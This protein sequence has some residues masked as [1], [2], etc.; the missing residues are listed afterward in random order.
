MAKI[1]LY[2][3]VN[4]GVSANL[5]PAI[6][7]AR[8]Q[9][10]ALNRLGGTVASLTKTI[11]DVEKLSIIRSKN[12]Q[13]ELVAERRRKRLE[14]DAAAEEAQELK[15]TANNK[16]INVPKSIGE[17]VKKGGSWLSKLFGPIGELL[18]SLATFAIAQ[19][20]L[21]WMSN[22]ENREKLKTFLEKV[23]FVWTKLYDFGSGL[24]DTTITGFN[25]LF[26]KD[27]SFGDRLKGL[28]QMMLGIIGLKYLLNPF[29]L[30]ADIVGLVGWMAGRQMPQGKKPQ[31]SRPP[32]VQPPSRPSSG[33]QTGVRNVT[34]STF[35]LEQARKAA[36]STTTPTRVS[37]TAAFRANLQ[38]GTARVPLSPGLQRAAYN[39]PRNVQNFAKASSAAARNMMGRIPIV[40]ALISGVYTYFEDVDPLDGQPDKNLS[41]ALF[42]AGGTAIGGFLGSFIP[43]PVLGTAL[44][45]ILGEYIGELF[46]ILINGGGVSAVG[47]KLQ[48]DIAELLKAGELFMGWMGDGLK[49]FGEG[50]P[51]I[52][53]LGFE[54][55]DP[56]F[57][58]PPG[59]FINA[60]DIA[61][62]Y[63]KAFF[64]R[65][66]MKD[67][68]EK[69]KNRPIGTKATLNGKEVYW[70]GMNYGWQSKA[71][72][73][74][75][76]STGVLEGMQPEMA[77]GGFLNPMNWF[78]P[79]QPT[80][81]GPGGDP[82]GSGRGQAQ[83][84]RT[85]AA[86]PSRPQGGGSLPPWIKDLIKLHEGRAPGY[87]PNHHPAYLDSKDLPTIGYGHLIVPGDGYSM[88]SVLTDAQADSLFNKDFIKHLK[89]AQAVPGYAK[90]G[91]LQKAALVDLVY[92]MGGGFYHSWPNFSKAFRE[93]NYQRAADELYDS[94]WRHDVGPRRSVPII[95]LM[96]GVGLRGGDSGHQG[97]RDKYKL[98]ASAGGGQMVAM[99]NDYAMQQGE[100]ELVP[101]IMPKLVPLPTPVA[102]NTGG[103]GVVTGTPTS[104]TKRVG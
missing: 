40:G 4:P 86:A 50:L 73:D 55:P 76:K 27:K 54:V 68:K 72:Y 45:A 51:K 103:G 53:I 32:A 61:K 79:Q 91:P 100:M 75:L 24:V 20:I 13:A 38:T 90:A 33:N 63:Y 65:D 15:K 83:Q 31:P 66:P 89:Q 9:T 99:S 3:F 104:L 78:R 93:G 29:S 70:C 34:R 71:S 22:P 85:P 16:K 30:I 37:R 94:K 41:K 52:N 28:G 25:D 67:E 56:F 69:D 49:R 7:A 14:R 10:L 77:E 21:N 97:I 48:K 62:L 98:K 19:N 5:T 44:G 43:I 102:I 80:Y 84:R 12:E 88:S 26:G 81:M 6:T 8:T 82:S 74:K 18:V 1:Q 58:T 60:L 101:I 46:Y 47:E 59:L 39:A 95:N 23:Q 2:K 17:K 64:T 11:Q 92:N 42:K 35:N 57:I 87:R 96:R 36:T